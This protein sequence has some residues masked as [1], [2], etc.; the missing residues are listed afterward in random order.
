[1]D[2][3]DYFSLL[4]LQFNAGEGL[5][6]LLRLSSSVYETGREHDI[7]IANTRRP[8]GKN[9]YVN[10]LTIGPAQ[11]TQLQRNIKPL[12]QQQQKKSERNV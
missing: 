2:L 11:H 7:S 4:T 9:G 6:I 12:W 1:M 5:N 3:S 8:Y 10:A